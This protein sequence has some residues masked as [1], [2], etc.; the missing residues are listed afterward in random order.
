MKN[1]AFSILAAVIF[2]A[3]S[4]VSIT[5]GL[6]LRFVKILGINDIKE[7]SA[8]L[9]NKEMEINNLN[10]TEYKNA[11]N[12]LNDAKQ[13]LEKNKTDYYDI[14][15]TSTDEELAQANVNQN[16]TMEFL[17]GRIGNHATEHGVNL[18]INTEPDEDPKLTVMNIEASGTYVGI[19]DFINE[20]EKDDKLAFRIENF[21]MVDFKIDPDNKNE[22]YT[23][24]VIKASF[25]I[26]KLNIKQE[27]TTVKIEDIQPKE[28][29]AEN[30]VSTN[31]VTDGTVQS[32]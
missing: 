19:K 6:D 8:E 17:W 9:K 4:A 11:L 10:N 21:K 16:Y 29:N 20:L 7:Q 23:E 12:K 14:A 25:S 3:L 1:V 5:K 30:T 15:S 28:E 27:D 13:A 26:K 32:E 18:T 31:E 22:A 2:I 24:N